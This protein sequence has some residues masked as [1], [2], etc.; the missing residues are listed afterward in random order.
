MAN[1][2]YAVKNGRIKGIF[3]SWT[4][5]EAQVKGFENA[6]YKSFSGA[7]APQK[8]YD[9]ITKSDTIEDAKTKVETAEPEYTH[10]EGGCI[11][12]T[13]GSYNEKTGEYGSG[14]IIICNDF[15]NKIVCK[16]GWKGSTPAFAT[17]QNVAGETD[18]AIAAIKTAYQNGRTSI[19]IYYDYTGI[20]YW[21]AKLMHPEISDKEHWSANTPTAKHYVAEL[22]KYIGKIDIRFHKVAAH[23]GVYYNEIA[24]KLAKQAVGIEA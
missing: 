17:S 19:D 4:D 2:I 11:A 24:D 10:P 5:C 12:F 22:Q 21:F 13:D 14:I 3:F 7:D 15:K 18:A 8:A 16:S 9:F 6:K 20:E 1:K 23:T